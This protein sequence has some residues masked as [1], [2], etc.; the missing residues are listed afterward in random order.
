M[1]E[2]SSYPNLPHFRDYRGSYN[3]TAM[4]VVSDGLFEQAERYPIINRWIGAVLNVFA[5]ASGFCTDEVY[6]VS[7]GNVLTGHLDLYRKSILV[8]GTRKDLIDRAA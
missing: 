4:L 6:I 2:G 1:P 8:V 3:H 7:S 5:G